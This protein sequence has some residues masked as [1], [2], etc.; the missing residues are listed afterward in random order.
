M[1]EFKIYNYFSYKT[2]CMSWIFVIFKF[3]IQI[4]MAS[5][6]DADSDKKYSVSRKN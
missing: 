1:Y 2:S 3:I 4:E 5:K 6:G